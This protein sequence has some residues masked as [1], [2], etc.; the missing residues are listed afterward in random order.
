MLANACRAAMIASALIHPDLFALQVY[1]IFS[2]STAKLHGLS[3]FICIAHAR[4]EAQHLLLNPT[5][6]EKRRRPCFK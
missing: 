2:P 6:M 1:L 3:T 5:G 4:Y